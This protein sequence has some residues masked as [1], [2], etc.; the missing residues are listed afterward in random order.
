MG[1]KYKR[2]GDGRNQL[3]DL[4]TDLAVH[5]QTIRHLST[6]LARAFVADDPPAGCVDRIAKAFGD[7]KG[8]LVAIHTAVVDEVMTYA[9]T[10]PKFTTPVTWLMQAYKATGGHVPLAE[11]RGAV[12]SIHFVYKEMGETYDEVP[13]PNGYSDLAADWISKAMIDRRVRQAYRIGFTASNLA[14]ETLG[15]YAERLAGKDSPLVP[16]VRRA[17]S[18]PIAVAILLASPQFLYI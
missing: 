3:A 10:M 7:S 11:P 17:E 9:Q 16:R 12:E 18:V 15:D 6:K 14:V 4:I 13:Q 8:D 2:K 5:P 1:K